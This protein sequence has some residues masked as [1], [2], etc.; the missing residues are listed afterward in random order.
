VTQA[1]QTI[2]EQVARLDER[3]AEH[4]AHIAKI[5]AQ[6]GSGTAKLDER[7][8]GIVLGFDQVLDLRALLTTL[9]SSAVLP[10]EAMINDVIAAVLAYT[11]VGNRVADDS[12]ALRCDVTS[13]KTAVRAAMRAT[14][15]TAQPGGIGVHIPP[16]QGDDSAG[17]PEARSSA[18]P[19]APVQDDDAAL[20]EELRELK[21]G[22]VTSRSFSKFID[23][24]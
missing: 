21:K 22:W 18:T 24:V 16:H 23:R 10:S 12:P 11:R 19:T 1:D 3:I 5:E 4:R 6:Y 15:P 7:C 13:A 2:I 8:A 17:R 9:Q 20:I 14:T